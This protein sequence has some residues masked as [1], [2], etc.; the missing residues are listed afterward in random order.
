MQ[1]S[2]FV[3]LRI[4]VSTESVNDYTVNVSFSIFLEL[5]TTIFK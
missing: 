4:K 5:L 3:Y 1:H 2:P